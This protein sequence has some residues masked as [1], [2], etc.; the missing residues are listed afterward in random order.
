MDSSLADSTLKKFG[1]D[2]DEPVLADSAAASTNRCKHTDG[3]SDDKT[4]NKPEK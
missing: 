2:S 4:I 1:A 3:D